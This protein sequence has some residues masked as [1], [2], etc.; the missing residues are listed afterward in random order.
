MAVQVTPNGVILQ[1]ATVN[2][3]VLRQLMAA[4]ITASGGVVDAGGYA[5]AQNGTPNMS[6]NCAAGRAWV[7]GNQIGNIGGTTFNTQGQYFVLNDATVNVPIAASNPTNPRIDIVVLQVL[8]AQY[9]GSS[10][11]AQLAVVTGT[12]AV[13]PVAPAAP[14]NSIT[15]AQ[16]AVAANATSIATGNLTDTR[17]YSAQQA[18]TN[19]QGLKNA[20]VNA[21]GFPINQ[22]GA[23]A[24]SAT[25]YTADRWLFTLGT[26]AAGAISYGSTPGLAPG[27]LLNY[28]AW[29]R[30]TA[31]T[32]N[33]TFEQRIEDVSTFAGQSATLSVL[34][35]ATGLIDFFPTLVQNFGTGGSPSTQVTTTG[36]TQTTING[37]TTLTW[38]FAVPSMSGKTIGTDA[39][40]S[41]LSMVLNRAWNATNGATGLAYLCAFQLELGTTATALEIPRQAETLLLCQRYY[42]RQIAATNNDFFASGFLNTTTNAAVNVVF[43]VTMRVIPAY[44]VSGAGVLSVTSTANFA[45]TASVASVPTTRCSDINITI[46]GG[47]AGQGLIAFL[48]AAGAWFDFSAEL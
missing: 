12:P 41:Y 47:T 28:L 45:G 5:V 16:V 29:S 30:T 13:T 25:G 15:L 7:P 8:D 42:W 1:N 31:G 40:T 39:N 37:L 6:V 11:L 18:A 34:V 26:G 23:A 32:T 22:R 4:T 14:S 10:N 48:N 2:A 36:S 33:S 20:L 38:T 44:A 46:A 27:A 3:Q 9:S 24:Y 17:T 21:A 19:A 35:Q 43:P